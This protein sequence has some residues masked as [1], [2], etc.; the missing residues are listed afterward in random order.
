MVT[1]SAAA[2]RPALERAPLEHAGTGLDQEGIHPSIA[3]L[4]LP[5]APPPDAYAVTGNYLPLFVRE[6]LQVW[7]REFPQI[8]LSA[9]SV[10]FVIRPDEF[11]SDLDSG[12]RH[13]LETRE[14]L[15]IRNFPIIINPLT[16]GDDWYFRAQQEWRAGNRDAIYI[17][18]TSLY[19]EIIHTDE[20]GD[21]R[22]AYKSSLDLFERFRKQGK[23]R[24][25]YANSCY[26]LLRNRCADLLHHPDR[27][28]Q[29]RIRFHQQDVALLIRSTGA[30]PR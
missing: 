1:S 3:R 11:Y 28:V 17:L 9:N 7:Q 22:Q 4:D 15:G 26:D 10:I 5:E 16:P 6:T 18:L 14:M 12:Q 19:H 24:S 20:S 27:Y 13:W 2:D 23:L 8:P 29:V 25:L 30:Q 21:E